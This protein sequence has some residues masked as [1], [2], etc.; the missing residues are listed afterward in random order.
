MS[1]ALRPEPSSFSAFWWDG[2]RRHERLL[3]RCT[4]CGRTQ[5]PPLPGCRRC[6]S[7]DLDVMTSVGN[8]SVYSWIV[9]HYAFDPSVADD[10]P[11]VVV[12]VE[13]DEGPRLYGR[14]L[15]CG[16]SDVWAG[17][18]VQVR[19]EDHADHTVAAFV[20]TPSAEDIPGFL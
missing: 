4:A 10:L 9:A 14:L 20:P 11:Y 12:T 8:G 2:L 5:F 16:P 7:G 1:K 19:Y 17:M 3:Q 13:L 6:G 15:G 18:P